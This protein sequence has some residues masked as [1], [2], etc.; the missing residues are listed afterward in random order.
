VFAA[1]FILLVTACNNNIVYEKPKEVHKQTSKENSQP[2]NEKQK[3]DYSV[4]DQKIKEK[5]KYLEGKFKVGMNEV[6]M[7]RVFGRDFK[8]IK[9]PDSEDG[10][11]GDRKYVFFEKE[12]SS[13]RQEYEVDFE[14]FE[15]RNL[16]VQFF[17][18]L[19]KDGK[20]QRASIVYIQEKDIM[21]RFVS[22]Q[23]NSLEK[24]N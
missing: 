24:I 22:A 20:A 18:G 12:H 13:S 2:D 1:V 15:N 4:L 9:N 6:E 14:N 23:E 17:I 8:L 16:G 5:V 19:T 10:T 3:I 21:F 7:D 11:A